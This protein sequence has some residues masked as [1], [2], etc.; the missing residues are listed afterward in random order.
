ML[1]RVAFNFTNHC[2]YTYENYP[3][4]KHWGKKRQSLLT[5]LFLC[6]DC[7]ICTNLGMLALCTWVC[8]FAVIISPKVSA[9][10]KQG[11][12]NVEDEWYLSFI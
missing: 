6:V 7:Y 1:R 3:G 2:T 5:E 12:E 10:F 11:H 9:L 4:S 8:G